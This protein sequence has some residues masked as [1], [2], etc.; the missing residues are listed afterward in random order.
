M[1]LL[2]IPD[3]V[4]EA[5]PEADFAVFIAFSAL[6]RPALFRPAL[7][8]LLIGSPS[9]S[10]SPPLQVPACS[11]SPF[12]DVALLVVAADS[13]VFATTAVLTVFAAVST[14]T[15]FVAADS[16]FPCPGRPAGRES[17]GRRHSIFPHHLLPLM[18]IGDFFFGFLCLHRFFRCCRFG[19]WRR[20]L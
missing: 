4:G 18:T 17:R 1:E 20:R 6:L 7:F 3:V 5:E 11:Q 12:V 16:T 19:M 10:F 15:A 2:A 14:A 9:T 8:F 13:A